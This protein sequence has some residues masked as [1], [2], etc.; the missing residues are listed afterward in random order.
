MHGAGRVER[1]GDGVGRVTVDGGNPKEGGDG[2]AP[3]VVGQVD[4]GGGGSVDGGVDT[5]GD[6]GSV[7]SPIAA[8]TEWAVTTRPELEGGGAIL[9]PLMADFVA[10]RYG[11]VFDTVFEPWCGPAHI[12]FELLRRGMCRELVCSDIN[13]EAVAC[14]EDTA[15]SMGVEDLVRTYCGDVLA[16]LRG[17]DERFDLVVGNPPNY[18]NINRAHPMGE[19]MRADLRP[20]DENWGQHAEFYSEIGLYLRPEALVLLTEINPYAATVFMPPFAGVPYD[21][22]P[23]PPEFTFR[24]MIKDGGLSVVEISDWLQ[25]WTVGGAIGHGEGPGLSLFVSRW[26]G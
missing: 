14:V 21:K 7:A 2:R 23:E 15:V 9:A 19:E 17:G 22:R 20:F 6:L 26:G 3:E 5:G 18:C 1:L 11:Q 25:G 4:G 16:P 10:S 24:Q 8:V 12:G 13:P